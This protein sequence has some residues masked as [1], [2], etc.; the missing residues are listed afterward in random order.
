MLLGEQLE[1]VRDLER[2]R[3]EIVPWLPHLGTRLA[4]KRIQDFRKAWAQACA[5][6]G[7]PGAYRHD[8]RRTAVRN[9]V[10]AGVPER[11]A[12]TITGHKT[13]SVFDRYHIVSPGISRRPP[14]G[15]LGIVLGIV[16]WIRLT[17]VT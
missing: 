15:W 12:M 2:S 14:G 6:A 5:V 11:V 1:R 10:N 13:R 4:G 8:F 7:V 16:G 17:G 9:L 3:Q